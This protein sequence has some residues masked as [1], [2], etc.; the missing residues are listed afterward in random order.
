MF[1]GTDDRRDRDRDRGQVGIGTLIVFI[2]MVLVAAIAAGVLINT[3]GFLQSSAEQSGEQ[4][5]EQV[6]NRL[7]ETSTTGTVTDNATISEIEMTLKLAP[8]SS[9]VNLNDTTIQWVTS[10]GSSQ[11]V[12]GELNQSET[13]TTYGN[14]TWQALR[15]GPD[16]D[17]SISEDSTLNDPVDRAIMNIN[18]VNETASDNS[19]QPMELDSGQTA[20]AQIVT[21]SGGETTVTL[22][23]PDS[24]SGK[25]SVQL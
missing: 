13:G 12:S 16:D 23:V 22:V 2:A 20:E 18:L 14:F 4:A 17:K 5:S 19:S 11:L 24:L 10:S 7:V 9:D 25:D 1:D 15:D 8:G 21:R 3:A 6:T